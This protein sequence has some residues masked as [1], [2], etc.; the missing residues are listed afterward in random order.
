MRRSAQVGFAIIV[1]GLLLI[2][3]AAPFGILLGMVGG[4]VVG[5]SRR[6]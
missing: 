6:S 2:P 1:L 4:M 3:V 5:F